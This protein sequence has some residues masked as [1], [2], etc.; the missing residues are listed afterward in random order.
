MD[1]DS[2]LLTQTQD[3]MALGMAA[4]RDDSPPMSKEDFGIITTTQ[5]RILNTLQIMSNE[6][7]NHTDIILKKITDLQTP[8]PDKDKEEEYKKKKE[9]TAKDTEKK[10][11]YVCFTCGEAGH[12]SPN[13]P[14]KAPKKENALIAGEKDT[15]QLSAPT[16]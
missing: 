12:C 5:D 10:P 15:G 1:F 11:K 16:N 9:T 6:I 3:P 13:C 14:Q 2:S 8:Q 7:D 4:Y